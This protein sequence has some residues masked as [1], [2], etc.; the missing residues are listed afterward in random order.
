MEGRADETDLSLP[1]NR[2]QERAGR[3]QQRAH[4]LGVLGQPLLHAPPH[5]ADQ[6]V[7]LLPHRQRS[8]Q[9]L[10][11]GR[12]PVLA[13]DLG[14]EVEGGVAPEGGQDPAGRRLVAR[15][16]Q[17]VERLGKQVVAVVPGEGTGAIVGD[18]D[19][20]VSVADEHRFRERGDDPIQFL[21]C[22]LHG[23]LCFSR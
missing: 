17:V 2:E 11:A 6:R 23:P 5:E 1:A 21:P 19:A 3:L 9:E 10:K 7:G 12:G 16:G 13:A 14:F 18:D 22:G 20:T 15:V 8:D 4:E